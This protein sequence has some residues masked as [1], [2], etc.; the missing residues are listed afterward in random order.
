[1]ATAAHRLRTLDLA[2]PLAVAAYA[3][4]GALLC[5]SRLVGLDRSYASDEL[6]TVRSYVR[7][8]VGE[9]LA[10][11]YIP[12]NHELFSLL[13]WA[14]TQV[15][16]ESAVALRLWSALP[17]L[18]G[19]ALVT[20]WL[21]TRVGPLSGVLFLFFATVS[22]LLLDI[23]RQARGYGLAFLAM[24]VLV[25]AALEA[26]RSPRTWLVVA[27]CVAGLVGTM[28]LPNFGVAFAATAAVLLTNRALRRPLV[29]GLAGSLL[30]GV[31]FYGPHF[32]DLAQ[33]SRQAYAAPIQPFWILTA[34]I[35]QTV[36]PAL[37]GIDELLVDPDLGSL[38]IAVA[39]AV[40][41]SASPLFRDRRTAVVIGAGVVV[42]I[43]VFWATR[44]HVAPRF[45]SFLL[46]PLFMLLASG[47]ATILARF[48]TT[49][50]PIVRTLLAVC[51]LALAVLEFAEHIERVAQ[52]PRE[53]AR[54]AAEFVRSSAPASTPVVAYV[55]YPHD[56][57]YFLGRP[58]EAAL[59]PAEAVRVCGL[60][61]EAIYV[62]Q[63]W[64]LPPAT[65]PCLE[66]AGVQQH[67]FEQYARGREMNV[68]VIPPAP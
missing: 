15:V 26:V 11:A 38:A 1:M 62:S 42:T 55:P 51:V 19:V 67:R 12:N 58:V 29:I 49:G 47:A 8:G 10:G 65:V 63:P 17:F 6:I 41:M 24:S 27:F 40:V 25:I 61:E 9:I 44:T 23:T 59:T 13:G 66:R 64:L 50:R 48:A 36:V 22:P 30:V 57:E 28:T 21:H 34:P 33:S 56:F 39:L 52:L 37:T 20:W 43:V 60:R 35:D 32:D 5:W 45:F 2:R 4:L 18:C 7:E 46:V 68:W 31:A 14:T 53:A 16:G 54:E 3:V